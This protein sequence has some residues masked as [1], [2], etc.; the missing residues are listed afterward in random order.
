MR[1]PF[2][3]VCALVGIMMISWWF[4][5]PGSPPPSADNPLSASTKPQV[6]GAVSDTM[7][8]TS[9]WNATDQNAGLGTVLTGETSD[10][11]DGVSTVVVQL[12]RATDK[13]VWD[14]SRWQASVGATLDT[15]LRGT[16]FFYTIPVPLLIN[17]SYVVRSQAIDARGNTQTTWSEITL[18]GRDQGAA[19]Q[20]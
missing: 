4:G 9:H 14:G 15:T 11:G 5:K 10:L 18:R 16:T 1:Q 13:A 7:P 3:S 8:P 19:Q 17:T 20:R 6:K 12:Q 2:L